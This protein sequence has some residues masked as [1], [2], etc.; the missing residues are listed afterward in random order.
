LE[1]HPWDAFTVTEDSEYSV[2]V[3]RAGVGIAFAQNARVLAASTSGGRGAYSQGLRW[4]AGR[5]QM[6]RR[7]WRPLL[8]TTIAERRFRMRAPGCVPNGRLNQETGMR[9]RPRR[10]MT[11][12]PAPARTISRRRPPGR[13]NR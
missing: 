9:W 8:R 5:F 2:T 11:G 4:E 1:N 3:R 13:W 10:E 12:C 7:W 6:L